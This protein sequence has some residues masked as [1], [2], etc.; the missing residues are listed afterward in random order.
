MIRETVE[1]Q[2]AIDELDA[3]LRKAEKALELM[4]E[5]LIIFVRKE[6]DK[7]RKSKPVRKSK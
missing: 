7:L 5:C 6:N 1:C 3:R 4:G 2:R